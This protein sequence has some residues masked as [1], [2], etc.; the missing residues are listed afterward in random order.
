MRISALSLTLSL[1]LCG[2][3]M[4]DTLPSPAAC[5][6]GR[7]VRLARLLCPLRQTLRLRQVLQ[8]RAV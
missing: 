1:L 3:A 5:E 7:N 6:K 2:P 8:G 4:A